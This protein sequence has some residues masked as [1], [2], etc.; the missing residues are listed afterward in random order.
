VVTSR[1]Y[2]DGNKDQG[3]LQ[4]TFGEADKNVLTDPSKTSPPN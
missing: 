1:G 3:K 2:M 4:G